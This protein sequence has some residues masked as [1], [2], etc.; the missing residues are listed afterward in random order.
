M[1]NGN[2]ASVII[3]VICE[4]FVLDCTFCNKDTNMIKT[5]ISRWLVSYK[6]GFIF[7]AKFLLWCIWLKAL[8]VAL[9]PALTQLYVSLI[10]IL[11]RF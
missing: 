7:W 11:H 8:S 2:A 4:C 6:K 3:N 9:N 10:W 1:G 5:E